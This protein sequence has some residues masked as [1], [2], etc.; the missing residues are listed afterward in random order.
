MQQ[1]ITALA[2][3]DTATTFNALVLKHGLP[4]E[5]YTDRRLGCSVFE[6]R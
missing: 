3:Y 2:Q 5:A 1:I 4:N 6:S